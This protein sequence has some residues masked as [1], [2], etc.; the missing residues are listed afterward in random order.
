MKEYFA[1]F[2]HTCDLKEDEQSESSARVYDKKW[3]H[4]KLIKW[5]TVDPTSNLTLQHLNS[6]S[7]VVREKKFHLSN[8][9]MTI[10]PFSRCKMLWEC[11]ML[12]VFL[13]GLIY[14]PM[15]YLDYVDKVSHT[16]IGNLAIMKWVKGFCLVDMTF[17]FFTGYWDGRNFVVSKKNCLLTNPKIKM[18]NSI[19]SALFNYPIHQISPFAVASGWC[20]SYSSQYFVFNQMKLSCFFL[21]LLLFWSADGLKP[22]ENRLEISSRFIHLG[23]A[24]Q[25]ASYDWS[26]G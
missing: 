25:R 8:H 22:K 1:K 14:A 26:H 23:L 20:L 5:I 12:S 10:H 9:P 24:N 21:F 7:T 18:I 6:H 4:G 13:C 3:L 19:L 11:V 15:Q 16:N 17:R 2:G